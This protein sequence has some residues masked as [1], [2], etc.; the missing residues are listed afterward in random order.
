VAAINTDYTAVV[1]GTITPSANG[2]FQIQHATEVAASA[3][4]IRNGSSLAYRAI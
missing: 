3:A 4:T 1:E 2:T